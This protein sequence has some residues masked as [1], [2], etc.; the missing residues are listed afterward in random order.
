MFSEIGTIAAG[1]KGVTGDKIRFSDIDG[2]L[3]YYFYIKKKPL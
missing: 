3:F 2:K 1:V